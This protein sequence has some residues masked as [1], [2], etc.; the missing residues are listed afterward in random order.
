M[1]IYY[2]S[3]LM[4]GQTIDEMIFRRRES[5]LLRENVIN[6]VTQLVGGE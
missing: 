4:H 1:H 3:L 2:L 5:L 6:Y